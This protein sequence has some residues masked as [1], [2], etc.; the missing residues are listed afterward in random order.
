[1]T[2]KSEQLLRK[3][4]RETSIKY[5]GRI[6]K[7]KC[8]T[9]LDCQDIFAAITKKKYGCKAVISGNTITINTMDNDP[10]YIE[11][12]IDRLPI[13]STKIRESK[14]GMKEDSAE[15]S[16]GIRILTMSNRQR[17]LIPAIIVKHIKDDWYEI[18]SAN[19]KENAKLQSQTNK[20]G[21]FQL[22]ENK[23][24]R[25]SNE[26]EQLAI[27]YLDF[28][29]GKDELLDIDTAGGWKRD[30]RSVQYFKEMGMNIQTA[31]KI[32]Q[33]ALTLE[34]TTNRK[35]K[36][37][38]KGIQKLRSLIRETIREEISKQHRLSEGKGIVNIDIDDELSTQR[39]DIWTVTKI[40]PTGYQLHA[41]GPNGEIRKFRWGYGSGIYTTIDRPFVSVIKKPTNK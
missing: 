41:R 8:Q 39:G 34:S 27:N 17:K 29:G 36:M 33:K 16:K 15:L 22:V 14:I 20:P 32:V 7:Y 13:T 5:M 30:K 4:I 37:E 38:S 2:N 10:E 18:N 12:V 28:I 21:E 3:M 40:S 11:S 24:I 31:D 19:G 35:S 23:S 6:L 1:M 25:E 9:S 26:I